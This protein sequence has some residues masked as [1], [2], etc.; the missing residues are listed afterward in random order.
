MRGDVKKELLSLE[1]RFNKEIKSIR[2]EKYDLESD[3]ATQIEKF[4]SVNKKTCCKPCNDVKK[5][6]NFRAGSQKA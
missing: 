1:M 4:A 5:I 3:F 6:K 2:Q